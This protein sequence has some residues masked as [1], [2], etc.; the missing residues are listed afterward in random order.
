[1]FATSFEKGSEFKVSPRLK[2][3]TKYPNLPACVP[4]AIEMGRSSELQ[5]LQLSQ[6]VLDPPSSS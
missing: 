1:M 2:F 3:P 4:R 6:K 5:N